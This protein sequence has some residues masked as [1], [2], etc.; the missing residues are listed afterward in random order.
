MLGPLRVWDGAAL[1]PIRAPQQRVVLAMLLA[2]AGR[3]VS[4]DRLID[5]IWA[6]RPPRAAVGTVQG[7]V[8][9]LRRMLGGDGT[10]ALV[11]RGHGYEM[12][13]GDDDLDATVYE[14]LAESGRRS[15][16]EGRL[17]LATTQLSEALALW[18]GPALADVPAGPVL[19]AET[20]RLEQSRLSALEG[21]LGAL[22]DL[23][24]HADVVDELHR[25]VGEHPLREGLWA[26]LMRALYRC[27][28]RAEGL[29]AYQRARRTLRD[30]LGLEPG[31]PLRDLQAAILAGDIELSAPAPPRPSTEEPARSTVPAQL[32]ADVAHFTDRRGPLAELDTM[33]PGAGDRHPSV[34]V[35]STIAGT[36]GVGKTALA[37]HW[38]H[39]VAD[40]FPDGQL[41]VDLRG[42]TAGP[43]LRPVE[44]LARFL[45][46]LGVPPRDVPME[47]DEAA[48][49]Y[50]SRLAGKRVLVLLDNAGHAEQ[51]RPLL[52]GS[53]GCV[54]VI[55]SRDQFGGLVAREGAV[56]VALDVLTP[57]EAHA[58]LTRLLGLDRANAEPAAITDLAA[59]CGYLPLALRIAA[60]NI[61]GHPG[62]SITEYN[63]RL[64]GDDRLNAL[65]VD[66]D[67]QA[68]VRVAL[69]YSYAVLPRAAQRLFRLL[70]LVPG[71]HFT[72]QATAALANLPR[73]QAAALLDR[74]AAAHLIDEH[75]PGRYSFHD[76]LRCYAA[77]RANTGESLP[78]RRAALGRLFDY[79][80][81]GVAAAAGQV[82]PQIMRLPLPTG[83]ATDPG[84]GFA[85]HGQA[86]GWLDAERPNLV[87][88]VVHAAEHGP[89]SAAWRLA[90]A[91]RG[92][93]YVRMHTVDW[94]AVAEAGLAAA[95]SEGDPR[96]RGASHLSLAGLH[97]SQGR[98]LQAIDHYSTALTLAR[99]AGWPEGESAALGNL[100]NLYWA[101]GELAAAADHYAQA[102]A[103]HRRTGQLAAQATDLG[104]LG[105]VYFGLG[106]LE[107]A[108]EQYTQALP[109]HREAG[110][111]SG[112]A[113]TLTHLGD[114]YH[115]LGRLDE[116]FTSL[117]NARVLLQEIGDRN[118]EGDTVRG[119]AAVLRDLGRTTEALELANAAVGL[120]RETGYQRLEAGART[121]R[122]S[123][124]H[125]LGQ[126]RSAIEDH[127]SAL[128]LARDVGNSY[129]ETEALIGLAAAHRQTAHGELAVG[130]AEE[131]LAIARQRGYAFLEDQ[132]RGVLAAVPAAPG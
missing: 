10:V 102:L 106:R 56:R 109:L 16:A 88:A 7:Y 33:L 50:R 41:Y 122:A 48:A 103:L 65:Q 49:L 13:I 35:I 97:W 25:L 45:R 61:A 74:L 116:A 89:A 95:E 12:Q 2:E 36:A 100:G 43:R 14:R 21:R 94:L 20:L 129:I 81:H 117:T 131:A 85:D 9:R 18:R 64:V 47:V 78:D 111:R 92:Y 37:V 115:A 101:L 29:E 91:M 96:G 121:T 17:E 32:P 99:Q 63:A 127:E 60:A 132:A 23:G 46:A 6:D 110:S 118:V 8:M 4:I 3:V 72:A 105:L 107:E 113:R 26:Q 30:Q 69:N 1:S 40:R 104:N 55:T 120:A 38:A 24:G 5:E 112:E 80:L 87:A 114:A 66:G 54:V 44:A 27:G 125:R 51:V 11:T 34:V 86:S 42:Y 128:R 83:P 62:A 28:R 90:D 75:T 76:L 71:P 108:A 31:Q 67:P 53:P 126:Y 98:L 70:G 19:S 79:Y 68:A 123:I 77:E 73:I 58:L 15:L 22:L 93:L 52:P 57:S 119:L 39:Q 130:H 124:R 59:L 84:E 82:S